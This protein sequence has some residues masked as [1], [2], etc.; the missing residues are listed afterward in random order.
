M[1]T[2]PCVVIADQRTTAGRRCIHSHKYSVWWKREAPAIGRGS[3][4]DGVLC[5]IFGLHFLAWV[6]HI[7]PAFEQSACVFA[8]ATSAAKAGAV[9]ASANPNATIIETSFVMTISYVGRPDFRRAQQTVVR[10]F[11]FL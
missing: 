7:P 6:S 10:S 9:T 3:D 8:D 11:R 2:N 4:F 1:A 5:Y